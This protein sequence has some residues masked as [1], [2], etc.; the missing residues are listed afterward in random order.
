MLENRAI[1]PGTL[2]FAFWGDL[3]MLHIQ[4]FDHPVCSVTTL[5]SPSLASVGPMSL[6][7]IHI[8]NHVSRVMQ[9]CSHAIGRRLMNVESPVHE[10]AFQEDLMT[11]QRWR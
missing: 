8:G 5:A 11:N 10:I 1:D 2:G 6:L 7:H 9:F 3:S 4:A